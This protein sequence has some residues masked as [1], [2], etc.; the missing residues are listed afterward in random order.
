MDSREK[1][2]PGKMHRICKDLEGANSP[3]CS[4]HFQVIWKIRSLKSH[5]GG[6]GLRVVLG[7]QAGA[8]FWKASCVW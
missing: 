8:K 2:V 3:G 4:A 1:L 5:S 6:G 7:K